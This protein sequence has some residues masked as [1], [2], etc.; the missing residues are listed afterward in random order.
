VFPELGR[1]PIGDIAP[2]DVRDCVQRIE[3]TGAGETAGRVFQRLRSPYRYAVAHELVAVDPTYPL[4]P[5]EILRPRDTQHRPAMSAQE[6][7]A[8]LRKL[9]SYGGDPTVRNALLLL[10]LTAVRPGELRAAEW[11]EIDEAGALW[12]IPAAHMKMKT[13]HLVPLSAQALAVLAEMRALTGMRTLIFPSPFYPTR[14]FSENTMNSA[15]ARMGYK[16][17]ATAAT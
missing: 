13:E 3:A 7:P 9:A 5:S 17:E 15:L 2:R 14:P 6:A 12:R 4:K 16:G 1:R 11:S 8:F 10:V